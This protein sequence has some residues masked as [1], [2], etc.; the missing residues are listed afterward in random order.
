MLIAVS[1]DRCLCTKRRTLTSFEALIQY[2]ERSTAVPHA[3]FCPD[4]YVVRVACSIRSLRPR[5]RIFWHNTFVQAPIDNGL[6]SVS[7]F[8]GSKHYLSDV[9]VGSTLRF[10]IGQYV[11][12]A[13]HRE[14]NGST[15]QEEKH[16]SRWPR[17]DPEYN[18]RARAYGVALNW[19]F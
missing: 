3:T 7:R 6:Q 15:D 11:Y 12:H 1:S 4:S 17:I 13:H 14:E 16:V 5:Y 18:R 10:A 2:H 8:T 9:L 19:K